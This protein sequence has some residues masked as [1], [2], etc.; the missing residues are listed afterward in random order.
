M[1]VLSLQLRRYLL[2]KL[3]KFAGL[4]KVLICVLTLFYYYYLSCL[5]FQCL[6]RGVIVILTLLHDSLDVLP[7]FLTDFFLSF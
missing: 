1:T 3:G 5:Q 7:C 4:K 6:V 2:E